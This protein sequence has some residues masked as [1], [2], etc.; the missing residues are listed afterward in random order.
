MDKLS[1]LLKNPGISPLNRIIMQWT[2]IVGENNRKL[3]FPFRYEYKTLHIAVPNTMVKSQFHT[4]KPMLLKKL[5]RAFSGIEIS[6]IHFSV[7]PKY[8]KKSAPVKKENKQKTQTI[9]QEEVEIHQAKLENQGISPHLSKVMA[10][11]EVL[12]AQRNNKS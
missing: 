11:I 2:G 4:I 3:L 6:Y 1:S 7:Q 12:F 10:E 9:S 8:F 5:R